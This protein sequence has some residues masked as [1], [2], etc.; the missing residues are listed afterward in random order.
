MSPACRTL[1]WCGALKDAWS[2]VCRL[3]GLQTK[4]AKGEAAVEFGA[5]ARAELFQL[6]SGVAYLNHGSYGATLRLL[7]EAQRWWQQRQVRALQAF[8]WQA[9]SCT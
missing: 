4:A 2:S 3:H 8:Q 9:V 6:R 1:P 7:S 5:A